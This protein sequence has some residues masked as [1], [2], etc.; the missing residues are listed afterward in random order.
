MKKLLLLLLFVPL[1][2][3]GQ[4]SEEYNDR[5]WNKFEKSDYKGALKDFNK[6]IELNPNALNYFVRGLTK[7]A[8]EDYNGAILDYNKTIELGY[9]GA[10]YNRGNAKALLDDIEGACADWRE[11]ASFNTPGGFAFNLKPDI[12]EQLEKR[13]REYCN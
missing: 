2:S 7:N 3:F 5:G 1:V 9:Y 8:L 4:T 6:V 12:K 11:A 13:I 10:Y